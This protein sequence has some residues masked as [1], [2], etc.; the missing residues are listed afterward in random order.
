MAREV[1]ISY[2]KED[3]PSADRICAALEG[4]NIKCWIAPRDVPVGREWAAAIVEALQ[5]C[6][7]FVMVLSSNS[8]NAKQIAREAELADNAGLPIITV[9]IEDVQPPPQLQYFLGNIQWLDA[10]DGEFDGAMRRLANVVRENARSEPLAAAAVAGSAPSVSPV[11]PASERYV[12]P[13]PPS[14]P[15]APVSSSTPSASRRWAAV[16]ALLALFVI[17]AAIRWA[18]R[19]SPA[20]VHDTNA[21]ANADGA[22]AF[23]IHYMQERD[24][25]EPKLAYSLTGPAFRKHMSYADFSEKVSKLKSRGGVSNYAPD[26]TCSVRE[27]GAYNCSYV[28]SFVGGARTKESLVIAAKDGNWAI[29]GDRSLGSE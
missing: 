10:F 24:S 21:G 2:R 3:K 13:Q 25:G 17:G 16:I 19:P 11:P 8:K 29:A 6:S 20:P 23:G 7:S 28:V 27:R 15:A 1:F 26:G 12:S 18:T 4:E 14:P 5:A 9:R 22:A